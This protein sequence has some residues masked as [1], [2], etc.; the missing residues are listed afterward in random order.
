MRKAIAYNLQK[1]FQMTVVSFL[2]QILSNIMAKGKANL[3]FFQKGKCLVIL[4]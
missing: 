4:E 1:T 2:H 3:P